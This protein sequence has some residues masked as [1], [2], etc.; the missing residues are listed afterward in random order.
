MEEGTRLADSLDVECWMEASSMGKPLYEKHG[1]ETVL[2]IA[3]NTEKHN[4]S[5]VW[6]K[7]EHEITP[8]PVFGM[9]RPKGR[10]SK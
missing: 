7:C 5:D 10:I 8:D 1:F 4:T 2:K 3:F 6:R 9:R